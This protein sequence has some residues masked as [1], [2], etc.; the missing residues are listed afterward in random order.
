MP[1]SHKLVIIGLGR[2]GQQLLQKLSRDFEVTCIDIHDN[3]AE[4]ARSIWG[5]ELKVI[6]G[7]ATSRLILED[8]GIDDA[9]TVII[10][11]TTEK[12][13]LEVVRIL[14]EHFSP[15][16]VISMGI[17]PSGIKS[18]EVQGA[19]VENIFTASVIGILNKIEQKSK[20]VHGIGLGKDEIREV[21]V[22]PNSKLANKTL[23]SFA[24]HNWRVGIIYRDGNIVVPDD[25][26]ILKPRDKV[27]IL[28]EPGVL[29][30]VSELLTFRF[31]NFP[32]EYGSSVLA[33]ITGTEDEKYFEE[34]AYLFS[35]F[36]LKKIIFACESK[37][38][39][40]STER[41]NSI[42][43][44][45]NFSRTDIKTY[46][47]SK[48]QDFILQENERYGIIF[49]KKNMLLN[50]FTG[51]GFESRRKNFLFRLSQDARSPILISN[52]TFPYDQAVVPCMKEIDV[53]HVM[54]NVFE[55][56]AVLHNQITALMVKP[57][58]YI[59]S[60]GALDEFSLLKKNITGLSN[61]YKLGVNISV[62][63]GNP[64]KAVFEKLKNY[65]LLLVD[66]SGWKRQGWF[67]PFLNPDV[68]WKII[69]QSPISTLI[70]PEAEETF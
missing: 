12:I 20:S 25:A 27:V 51:P 31:Q 66:T 44:K 13:N 36:Q 26:T 57:S 33:C 45:Y 5:G 30:T 29:N 61:I 67:S 11:L 55:M 17:T 47:Q 9:D 48:F 2:I 10:T 62:L 14:K 3:R 16:R 24:S 58:Q 39:S 22:H 32:L 37:A 15:Q 49:M 68:V 69:C 65:S 56:A 35:A 70:I 64:V 50:S 8:A 7:D 54:E 28:G 6:T 4:A 59:E 53:N 21:E 41:L 42:I 63:H 1:D 18:L 34:L 19:E 43:K 38:G 23:S 52:A 60:E 46:S 40:Q